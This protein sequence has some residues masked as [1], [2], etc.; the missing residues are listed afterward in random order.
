ME[1]IGFYFIF[2]RSIGISAN[3]DI[4]KWLVSGCDREGIDADVSTPRE[5]KVIIHDQSM[6]FETLRNVEPT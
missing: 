2:V 6:S 4:T 5:A 1:N 3:S